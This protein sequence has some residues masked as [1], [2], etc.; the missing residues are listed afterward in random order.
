MIIDTPNSLSYN[1]E[2]H[3]AI[4]A[5]NVAV[6]TG[7]AYGGIGFAVAK[8]LSAE[9]GMKVVLA[10]V[11]E[12]LL[13]KAQDKLQEAGV[14]KKNI[15]LSTT[16]VTKI[17]QVQSLAD[18]VFVQ[19]GQVDVLHLNAGMGWPSSTWGNLDAWHNTI[20]LN[21]FGVINGAN[22]FVPKML[23]GRK[24]P[25]AVIVTGSKQGITCPPGNP[26]Y[27]VSKAAVKAYTEQ[28]AH[29][30]RSKSDLLSAYLLVPGWVKTKFG[31]GK[32]PDGSEKP[33]GAWTPDQTA[34]YMLE[35]LAKDQFYIICPDNDV[36]EAM[37]SARMS[38]SLGDVVDK[39]PALSRWHPDY[40]SDFESHMK[41]YT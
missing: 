21:L 29:E 31:S 41:K 11:N 38:W 28:L 33:A 8:K 25:G 1:H 2:M 14:D 12:P 34:D 30:L 36:T 20:N 3:P 16:D 22:T 7:S 32:D 15:L 4:K 9:N 37:D 17:E 13:Q 24:T 6:I 10:D 35:K 26:A 19:F 39:R 23:E 5:G 40:K 18:K 27:N